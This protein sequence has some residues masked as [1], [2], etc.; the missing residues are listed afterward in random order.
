MGF[1]IYQIAHARPDGQTKNY[2]GLTQRPLDDRLNAHFN[3]STRPKV[4]GISHFSLGYAV[5]EHLRNRA[6]VELHDVFSITLLETF[7]TLEAMREGE[8]RWIDKLG[9]MAPNGYNLMRGGSSVGGPSNAIPCSLWLSDGLQNFPSFTAAARA[10]AQAAG[11]S[12][13]K[14]IALFTDRAKMRIHTGWR[15]AEALGLE[16]RIDGRSTPLSLSAHKA[17]IKV[18]TARS[19]S[20]RQQQRGKRTVPVGTRHLLPSPQDPSVM[21]PAPAVFEAL[22]ISASTG[23]HRLAKIEDNLHLMTPD[24]IL[25]YLRTSKD[26][27]KPLSI[28][29]PGGKQVVMGINALAKEYQSLGNGFAVIKTRLRQLGAGATNQELLIA[30]GIVPRPVK[31]REVAQEPV[32]RKKHCSHWFIEGASNSREF[33][34][35]KDFVEACYQ[36]LRHKPGGEAMLGNAPDDEYK[37]KRSLQGR[38]SRGTREK[39]T[40]Q[41]LAEQLGILDDLLKG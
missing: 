31:Q 37:A 24:A 33:V 12:D 25:E 27:T 36:V 11:I 5:R 17:G 30:L 29:L 20:H 39:Q 40:V 26:R 15:Q 28:V 23:R 2:V 38:I 14:R 13:D 34:N 10:V 4:R 18:D 32:S 22:G 7:D 19:Q 41:H 35:Q 1:T 9:T 3:E 16:P 6:G 21:L 8:A